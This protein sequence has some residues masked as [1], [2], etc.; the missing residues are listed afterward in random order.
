ML[1]KDHKSIRPPRLKP[2]DTIGIVA[3]AGPFDPEKFMK[4]KAVLESMGF[5]T[6]FDED[7]FQKHGFLAGT[8]SQRL[9]QV[10]RLFADPCVQAIICARGGYGSMRILPFLDFEAIQTHPKIFLGFSDVSALLSVLCDQCGLITFHGPLVTTL[11]KATEKTIVAMKTALTSDAPLVLIP[12]D[13]QVIKSG[14]CSGLV[15]G[16]N[17]TTLCHL[18]GTPYAPNFKGKILFFEDVGEMPYRIDRMLTQMK[19]AGCFKE[20]A[21][22]ILGTFKDC[23]QL[24]EIVGIFNTIFEDANIPI[25]AGFNM[26]HGEHNLTI[27]MGLGATL[28]TDKKRLLFHEPA[29]LA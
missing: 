18:V 10:N 3:P 8:D 15:T 14:V 5:Q 13:G 1:S 21:G 6:F 20:I 28:D 11:A 9:E 2:G 16:G 19:M 27:P 26:G 29:T 12:E 17:L 24:N 25:L 4:G 23:G 7:I 22:L